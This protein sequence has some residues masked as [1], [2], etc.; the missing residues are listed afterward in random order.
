MLALPQR[1]TILGSLQRETPA[2][3][4]GSKPLQGGTNSRSARRQP[5]AVGI[6]SGVSSI[7]R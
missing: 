2:A 1:F 7:H 3:E 6:L 5:G 4:S